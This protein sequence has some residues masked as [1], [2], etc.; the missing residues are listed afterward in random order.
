ML[1]DSKLVGID[2]GCDN[3]SQKLNELSATTGYLSE[4]HLSRLTRVGK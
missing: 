4:N 1:G 3:V 2:W